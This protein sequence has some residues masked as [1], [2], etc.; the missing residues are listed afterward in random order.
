MT[1]SGGMTFTDEAGGPAPK[2]N[3][4]LWTW[5]VPRGNGGQTGQNNN[6]TLYSSPTQVGSLST[7]HQ[8][9]TPSQFTVAIK[10]DGTIWSWGSNFAGYL[11]QNDVADR[12]SPTQIGTG[13]TW[14][15]LAAVGSNS[16]IT[17]A[18]KDDGTLWGWG[19]GSNGQIGSNDTINRS[20]PV[21]I[22]TDTTWSQV[23]T[24]Q[25][26]TMAIKTNG[27]LWAWGQ[28]GAS[29]AL[30]QNGVSVDR[31]SPIQVGSG[32][33]WSS[34]SAGQSM[35][36][37]IKTDGT[38]WGWGPNGQGQLGLN[39]VSPRS[40]PTQIGALTNWASVSAGGVQCVA[41][42][43]DGTLWA[44]GGD[45]DGR[46]G[47][48]TVQVAR[49]SPTQIG[50]ATNWAKAVA[51]FEQSSA[52]TTTKQLYSWGRNNRSTGGQLGLNDVISRSSPTQVGTATNWEYA[53]ADWFTSAGLRS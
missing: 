35:T 38:L 46:L 52:I 14:N 34:V 1:I 2:N 29:G 13:T 4:T 16:N 22:G 49:S 8:V 9:Y 23:T 11:G 33:N 21:Q 45:N 47:L 43:T 40:S 15:K 24:G 39:D 3:F 6:A 50:T 27:T 17:L 36:M 51:G 26:W 28:D 32:T 19:G 41:V 53:Q 44:W 37:A 12:S 18:I 20:S 30:G 7:W 42:K 5:G 31:S 10:S 25:T 48:N